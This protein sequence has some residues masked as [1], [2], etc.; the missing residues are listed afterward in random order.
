MVSG[1]SFNANGGRSMAK[2][3]M[4]GQSKSDDKVSIQEEDTG[5]FHRTTVE[6]QII[7]PS[8]RDSEVGV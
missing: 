7:S 2:G 8:S 5:L 6:A 3:S 1:T 4:T